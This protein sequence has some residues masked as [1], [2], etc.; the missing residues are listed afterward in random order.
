M[1]F[2]TAIF[3]QRSVHVDKEPFVA[4]FKVGIVLAFRYFD[5]AGSFVRR[6]CEYKGQPKCDHFGSI[7]LNA[8]F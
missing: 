7:S 2:W 1:L 3:Y 6:T 5:V 4:D 8:K